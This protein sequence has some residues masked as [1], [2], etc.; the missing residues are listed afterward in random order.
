M[1]T[2]ATLVTSTIESRSLGTASFSEEVSIPGVVNDNV[3][4]QRPLLKLNMWP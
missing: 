4:S 2:I 3:K 1:Q